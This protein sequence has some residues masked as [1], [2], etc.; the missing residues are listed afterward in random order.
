MTTSL[1]K[2]SLDA[3]APEYYYIK[4]PQSFIDL[5]TIPDGSQL[6]DLITFCQENKN[7]LNLGIPG[8]AD[9]MFNYTKF[10]A[11]FY[12]WPIP[13]CFCWPEYKDGAMEGV[14]PL[15]LADKFWDTIASIKTDPDH[16]EGFIVL[17]AEIK[18][19][20]AGAYTHRTVGNPGGPGGK[21]WYSGG[22]CR[23]MVPLM[24]G[25]GVKWM[26]GP[27]D[28]PTILEPVENHVYEFNNKIPY[29]F[30]NDSTQDHLY[31]QIDLIPAAKKEEAEQR[32]LADTTFGQLHV[33]FASGFPVH[34]TINL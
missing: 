32:I 25:A 22:S 20:P 27:I 18:L 34:P 14:T 12:H 5:G 7:P 8:T 26:S 15:R 29:V 28:E 23:L 19:F 30:R 16:P 21:L 33:K 13:F 9:L 4:K 24:S 3:S 31:I 1:T 10:P 11:D 17:S 6:P 2:F